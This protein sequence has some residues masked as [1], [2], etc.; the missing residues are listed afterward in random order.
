MT[1]IIVGKNYEFSLFTLWAE[2]EPTLKVPGTKQG[3]ETYVDGERSAK[4]S[5]SMSQSR[6]YKH[7]FFVSSVSWGETI[8]HT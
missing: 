1:K 6:N 8:Q 4:P 2:L 7:V 5:I 3:R